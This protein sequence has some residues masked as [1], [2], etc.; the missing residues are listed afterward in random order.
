MRE[1]VERIM[2]EV[3][4]SLVSAIPLADPGMLGHAN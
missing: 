4:P 3:R 1:D 2:A